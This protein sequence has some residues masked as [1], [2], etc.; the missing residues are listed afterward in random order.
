MTKLSPTV[1]EIEAMRKEVPPGPVVMVNLVRFKPGGG[2][3]AYGEYIK[4][5]SGAAA[6]IRRSISTRMAPFAPVGCCGVVSPI[7]GQAAASK[8]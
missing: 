3:A 7:S 8:L 5:T 2:K 1:E 6:M 4:A